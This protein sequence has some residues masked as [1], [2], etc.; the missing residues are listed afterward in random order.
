MEGLKQN[1]FS[2]LY[3]DSDDEFFEKK[4]L[5]NGKELENKLKLKTEKR[6]LKDAKRKIEEDKKY[7]LS[8]KRTKVY[9]GIT[10]L[11][12]VKLIEEDNYDISS[13]L[14]LSREISS[15]LHTNIMGCAITYG[16]YQIFDKDEYLY[17]VRIMEKAKNNWY[18]NP[19]QQLK[20]MMSISEQRLCKCYFNVDKYFGY[21]FAAIYQIYKFL[22]WDT[23]NYRK[24]LKEPEYSSLKE[25]IDNNLREFIDDCSFQDKS[26]IEREYISKYFELGKRY[27]AKRNNF[28]IL[29]RNYVRF[30][31]KIMIIKNKL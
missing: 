4:R 24:L 3:I 26:K 28:K 20:D 6:I 30:I 19:K 22:L 1:L 11:D 25:V 21:E 14:S 27:Y 5:N 8:L 23:P 12:Y 31:G 9:D 18:Y 29:F 10:P 16:G 7:A 15:S 17:L 2:D 13:Y